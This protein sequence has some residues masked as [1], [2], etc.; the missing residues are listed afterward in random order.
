VPRPARS[1]KAVYKAI[2]FDDLVKSLELPIFVI[3]ANPGSG[4][5]QAPESRTSVIEVVE[6]TGF[7][8][9]PE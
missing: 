2:N 1:A 3:P 5:G 7:R 6:N 4:P 8:L 9:P